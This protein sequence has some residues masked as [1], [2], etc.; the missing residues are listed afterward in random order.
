MNTKRLR[1]LNK[2][3]KI[4]EPLVSIVINNYNYARF[5]PEAIESALAQTYPHKEI[6]VVDD[7][8]TDDSRRVM[9]SY[10]DR[11]KPIYKK[12]GGQ[13]S[14]MNLGYEAA[15]GDLIYFL[16]DTCWNV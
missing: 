6:I 13:A 15:K 2:L 14:A 3:K 9:E 12:N 10:G 11:I 8:S 4:A 5:L 7:G 1:I 16:D